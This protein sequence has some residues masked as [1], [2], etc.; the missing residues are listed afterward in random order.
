MRALVFG[1][2][3]ALG[4]AIVLRLRQDGAELIAPPHSQAPEELDS[5]PPLDA[6][7]WA[8]GLNAADSVLAFD[9]AGFE[10]V[11]DAN[12]TYVARTLARLVAAGR[13]ADPCRLCVISSIWQDQARTGKFSYTVSKAAVAGLVRSCAADLGPRGVLINAVLPGVVDTPMSRTHL[14]PEQIAGVEAAT[15]LGRLPTPQDI[16]ATVAF[17]VGPENRAIT[18]QSLAVDAGFTA[19]RRI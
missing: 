5:L 15:A 19:V 10:A 6:V 2:G 18:G 13:L 3:G 12:V 14:S 11:L 17:L 8:Q 16:A 9:P 1:G 7:V 4:S